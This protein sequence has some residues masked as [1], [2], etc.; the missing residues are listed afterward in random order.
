MER[1]NWKGSPGR[2][3]GELAVLVFSHFKDALSWAL[4]TC[5]FCIYTG[6]LGSIVGSIPDLC[7]KANDTIKRVT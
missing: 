2:E 5:T 6:T 7:S 3:P 1:E 4:T